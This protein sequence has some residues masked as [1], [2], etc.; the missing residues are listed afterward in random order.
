MD[1]DKDGLVSL[2]EFKSTFLEKDYTSD[3][4]MHPIL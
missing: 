2:D 4:D 3:Y 1:K